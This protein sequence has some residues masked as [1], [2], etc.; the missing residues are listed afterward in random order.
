VRRRGPSRSQRAETIQGAALQAW[1]VE[2]RLRWAREDELRRA[3]EQ[4]TARAKTQEHVDDLAEDRVRAS[5]GDEAAKRRVAAHAADVQA[6]RV[7][8]RAAGEC[9]RDRVPWASKAARVAQMATVDPLET[10]R[11]LYPGG[12]ESLVRARRSWHAEQ[13]RRVGPLVTVR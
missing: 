12:K 11:Y 1:H 3:L 10:R 7:A 5:Y 6:S 13:A 2:R 8:L 4:D 9:A